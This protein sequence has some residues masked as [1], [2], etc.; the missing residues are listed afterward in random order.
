MHTQPREEIF[1][2]IQGKVDRQR[3]V[4]II[5]HSTESKDEI[6]IDLSFSHFT[7]VHV[8][9]STF[10]CPLTYAFRTDTRSMFILFQGCVPSPVSSVTCFR[11][12]KLLFIGRARQWVVHTCELA[13]IAFV[14][15][16][17]PIVLW[18]VGR[19]WI[20]ASTHWQLY[21]L[22]LHTIQMWYRSHLYPLKCST[23]QYRQ[24]NDKVHSIILVTVAQYWFTF[25]DCF[26]QSLHKRSFYSSIFVCRSH[27]NQPKISP[28]FILQVTGPKTPLSYCQ[29]N[30]FRMNG[31]GF[32]E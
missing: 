5:Y 18:Y 30:S 3:A 28:V 31:N 8:P 12:T 23:I 29:N 21:S 4:M 13:R 16:K 32:E 7:D 2:Y 22:P 20:G 24:T 15:T 11:H 19:S 14:F 17:S 10:L 9:C 26:K 27:L 6:H 25:F 1:P